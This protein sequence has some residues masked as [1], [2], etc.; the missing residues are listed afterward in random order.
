MDIRNNDGK[1]VCRIYES[2][3]EI[4]IE[5]RMKSCTTLLKLKISEKVQVINIKKVA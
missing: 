2:A 4:I 1:L 3:E 5:I